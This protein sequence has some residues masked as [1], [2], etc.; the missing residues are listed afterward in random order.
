VRHRDAQ[1]HSGGG[2]DRLEVYEFHVDWAA[3]GSS[4]FT[5][6]TDVPLSAF[7]SALCGLTT[8]NC[9][10]QPGTTRTLDPLREQVMFA[11]RYRNVG[12]YQSLVANFAVDAG[13]DR[14]GTR[15]FELRK[16]TGAWA[17]Q[18]E[19]TFAPGTAHRWMGSA[20]NDRRGNLGLG[21]SLSDVAGAVPPSVYYN[22]RLA[23][24]AA[25]TL[26]ATETALKT[27]TAAQTT[28]NRWGDYSNISVDPVDGCTFW[29]TTEYGNGSWLTWIGKFKH[30][31]CLRRSAADFDNSGTG[32]VTVYRAG[33]WLT[34]DFRVGT[35]TGV[36][37]GTAAGCIPV[38]MDYDGDGKTDRTQ[39]C[40]G[41][42]HFYNADGSYNKGIWVGNLAGTLPVP[43]DYNGDGKDDVVA[44]RNGAWFF[45]DFA[46]GNL[47][48]SV[49]TGPASSGGVDPIPAPMD[50]DGDGTADLT[51]FFGG[52][53][54]FFNDNGSYNKGI[55]TSSAAGVLP[56]PADYDGDGTEDVVIW[57][58][59]AWQWYDFATGAFNA[60]KSVF[61]GAPVFSAITPLPAPT[62][63]DGD[64]RVDRTVYSGGPWHFYKADGTYYA[65]VWTGSAAG[66]RALSR[67]LLP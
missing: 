62:D 10:P 4:T 22:G 67:R 43:A 13:S 28:F 32:D 44:F 15:W 24:D 55:F 6:P 57:N 27:S 5:G 39:L 7:D 9:I 2:V 33:T 31:S 3:P 12:P 16:T 34:T 23:N 54:H 42:W 63:Y 19:G 52:P 47:T 35:Q 8:L 29:Y 25:G 60:G 56:V 20:A 50:Y 17:L 65:G 11:I 38:A 1:A 40:N 37:T 46:T 41:A 48:S 14:A 18:N 21:Y 53:W 26:F 58:A 49:F 30:D 59:G 51:V 64:G 66:D 61:T 45:Y 36:F